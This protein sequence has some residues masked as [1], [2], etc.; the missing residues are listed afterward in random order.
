MHLIFTWWLVN[1]ELNYTEGNLKVSSYVSKSSLSQVWCVSPS[2]YSI[3][4]Q[5][6]CVSYFLPAQ[7]RVTPFPTFLKAVELAPLSHNRTPVE[8]ARSSIHE[9]DL[10]VH[11]THSL[12]GVAAHEGLL[13]P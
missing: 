1:R 2:L 6:Q 13:P 11:K 5:K 4:Q 12:V 8:G 9:E 3:M 10:Y 7:S